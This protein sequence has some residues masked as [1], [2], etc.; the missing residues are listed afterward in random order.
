MTEETQPKRYNLA[1]HKELFAQLKE[2]AEAEGITVVELLRRYI[3]LGLLATK[4]QKT[5]GS[6][7]VIH[8][9]GRER[10]VLLL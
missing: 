8:E 9:G 1:I 7:L 10:Q 4:I 6:A 5:P 2:V 3:K